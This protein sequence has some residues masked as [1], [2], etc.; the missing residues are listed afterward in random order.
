MSK[1]QFKAESKRLLD[2]MIH[3]IYTHREIFL[4][5]LISNASDAI[6]K[7]YYAAMQQGKTGIDR[8]T[9]KILL[10]TDQEARTLS[11]TDN[12]CG[13][14]AEELESNLGTIAKSGTRAFVQ[15]HADAQDVDIIGKFGVGFYAAF[16]VSK[17]VQVY[18]RTE[19]GDAHVWESDGVD[20]YTVKPCDY[21][22]VG[23]KI[24]L[25][26][27]D[28]TDEEN[29]DEYLEQYQLMALVKKYS[30]YIRYPICM[31]VSREQKKEGTE[32]EYETIVEEK[33]LNSMVPLW[34]RNKNEITEEEYQ[35][36]YR[37]NFFDYEAPITTLHV[38]AEGMLS[39]TALLFVPSHPAYDFNTKEFK[40]GLKLYANG[41][42]IMEHCEELLPEYFNF[43][44]GLVDSPDLSLNIS[45]E[46]LQ[47]DRQ[48]SAIAN[49][50]KKK[51]QAE[52]LRMMKDERDKYVGFYEQFGR[53]LKFGVYDKYGANKD[54]LKDLLL[55]HSR[56]QEKLISL[57]EYVDNMLPDQKGIYYAAGDS[58]QHVLK[59]PQT[60]RV[61]EKGY[62][63]LCLTDDV[64]EFALR[65]LETY[66]EKPFLSVSDPDL[67]LAG[68]DEKKAM[69]QKREDNK[70]LM[71]RI[72]TSLGDKVSD[73]QLT[74]RLKNAVACLTGEEG[75]SVEMYKVL[76]NMP[77]GDKVPMRFKLELNPDHPVF[78]KMATLDDDTLADYAALVLDQA[79]LMAGL[80]PEDPTAFSDAV[81][82]LM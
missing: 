48:L 55:F 43:V 9:F 44:R 61:A 57:Q 50:L 52:L 78:Q 79:K 22:P 6:D 27:S 51:I 40:R 11:I 2:L 18:S 25:F 8:S 66:A 12:G 17:K 1:K 53:T 36:F 38:R 72:K 10:E 32:D 74:D 73:V 45:R 37:D 60:E 29:F 59:L 82:K 35:Q 80:P 67:D 69:E 41:V 81:C 62:D 39:Y 33:T 7:R 76:R 13:M 54:F 3:S 15:E 31:Q 19:D 26:L 4:R 71:E 77:N 42:M 58:L 68:E 24:V 63:I 30:D 28:N 21:A 34:R 20:G 49:N 23:T 16:M 75:M 64:D 46:M 5:E 65:V 14:T 47:H 70:E 56:T